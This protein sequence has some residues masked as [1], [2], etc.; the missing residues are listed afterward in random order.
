MAKPVSILA[1]AGSTRTDSLNKKLV[2]LAAKGAEAAGAAV[3]VIDLRDYALPL[4]D[5]DLEAAS[6]IPENG[7]KL[8]KLFESHDGLLISSPENNSGYSAV[9]KN[10]LD[11]VSRQA[12]KEEASMSG[13]N[14]KYGALLAASPGALGGLRGLFA[15]RELLQ[16]MGVTILPRMQAVG[17][18]HTVFDEKGEL[19]DPK[20]AKSVAGMG[21]GLVELLQKV[22]A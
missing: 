19:K 20:L 14:G 18:A 13:F 8:K 9:L 22:R 1:F 11:W 12:T 2:R 7:L 5:G 16:N 17:Q 10:A 6:G 15:L 4:Y 3:T 21:A